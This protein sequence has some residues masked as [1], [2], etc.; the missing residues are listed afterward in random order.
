MAAQPDVT[1]ALEP[2]GRAGG[3]PQGSQL[4]LTSSENHPYLEHEGVFSELTVLPTHRASEKGHLVCTGSDHDLNAGWNSLQPGVLSEPT[5][6][7]YTG[8]IFPRAFLGL[9]GNERVPTGVE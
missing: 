8:T 1:V 5:L 6:P 7:V 9:L 2:G 4:K 3:Q